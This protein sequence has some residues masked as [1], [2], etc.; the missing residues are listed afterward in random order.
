MSKTRPVPDLG[1][2][3]DFAVIAASNARRLLDDADLLLRRGRYPTAYSVA[4]LAFEE[5]GKAWACITA[6][7]M[8]GDVRPEWPF[9]ELIATHVDKLM[10]A[11]AMAHLLAFVRGGERRARQPR[12]T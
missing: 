8:P 10:S 11:H 12:W 1:A 6:M 9:G 3:G 5:A 7:G 2:L 4:V